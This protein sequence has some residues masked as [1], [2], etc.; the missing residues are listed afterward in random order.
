MI[1]SCPDLSPFVADLAHCETCSFACCNTSEP[2]YHGDRALAKF[3]GCI[4]NLFS[5]GRFLYRLY[6]DTYISSVLRCVIFP[7]RKTPVPKMD[8][9]HSFFQRAVTSAR[10]PFW[11]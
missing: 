6:T 11:R 4:D 10:S 3:Y 2:E 1:E 5:V 9:S 7:R 8:G